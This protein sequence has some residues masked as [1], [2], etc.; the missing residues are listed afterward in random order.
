MG[1][2]SSIQ[3]INFEDIQEAIKNKEKYIIINTLPNILQE[4]LITNT[5]NYNEEEKIINHMLKNNTNKNII[6]YGK[7]AN[8][9]TIYN[10]YE[11]LLKLGFMNVF[12][13]SGGMFEWL[14]LQDIYGNELF[15]T[16]KKE[17][18]ILKYKPISNFSKLYLMID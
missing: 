14:C 9:D 6:I 16:T 17:L 3:R 18:D 8:D 15:P 13:Y 4:C 11:Q 1:N 10:K 7:N 2:H 12:I 5:I